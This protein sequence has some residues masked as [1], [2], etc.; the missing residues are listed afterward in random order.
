M[1]LLRAELRDSAHEPG[2]YVIPGSSSEN[3]QEISEVPGW[4]QPGPVGLVG[5]PDVS[6]ANPALQISVPSASASA[7]SMSTPR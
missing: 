3:G 4:A 2:D 7:S 6:S 5:S 1:R